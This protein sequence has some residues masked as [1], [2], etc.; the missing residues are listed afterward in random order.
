[1]ESKW[2]AKNWVKLKSKVKRFIR[3]V[4]RRPMTNVA[5]LLARRSFDLVEYPQR[6]VHWL[7]V[8]DDDVASRK[9]RIELLVILQIFLSWRA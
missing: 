7:L 9:E 5:S 2:K 4:I 1:M 6:Q 8:G 3:K